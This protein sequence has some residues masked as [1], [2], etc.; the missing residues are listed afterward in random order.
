MRAFSSLTAARCRYLWLYIIVYVY[1]QVGMRT[2]IIYHKISLRKNRTAAHSQ[3]RRG[4]LF[5]RVSCPKAYRRYYT[6]ALGSL[7]R[8]EHQEQCAPLFAEATCTGIRCCDVPSFLNIFLVHVP[9]PLDRSA[10][11]LRVCQPSTPPPPDST[12]AVLLFLLF[13]K[14]SRSSTQCEKNRKNVIF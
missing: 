1:I 8:Y 14:T 11:V 5:D 3:R 2:Y 7:V 12:T 9:T 4:E 13:N 6:R 10:A